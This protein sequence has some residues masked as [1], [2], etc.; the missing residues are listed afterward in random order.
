MKIILKTEV[1]SLGGYGEIARVADGYARNYLIPRGMAVEATEGNRR[2]FESE[3][4]A[5]LRKQ[6]A[7]IEASEKLKASLEALALSFTRKTAEDGEKLF[8]SVTAHDI[9][10]ALREKGFEVE[11]KDIELAEP[12][13]AVGEFKAVVKLHAGVSAEIGITVAKEE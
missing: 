3:K 6:Q 1:P 7:A 13:K 2:Q 9:E 4:E 10:A 5:Y 8:G 12:I 11:R